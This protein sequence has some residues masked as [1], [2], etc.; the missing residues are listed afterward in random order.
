M[1]KLNIVK[2]VNIFFMFVFLICLGSMNI[3]A[4]EKTV[5]EQEQ[6]NKAIGLNI[7]KN[8]PWQKD[9]MRYEVL[10]PLPEII[11][12][13]KKISWRVEIKGNDSYLGDVYFILKLYNKGVLF[14][15]EPIRVRIEIR[16]EFIVSARNL[17]RD[18]II[19]AKDVFVQKR[20]VRSM[21][22]N[23]VSSIDEVIGKSLCVGLRP[24]M[25]ITRNMLKE[26]SAVKRNKMVQVVLD[27]GPINITTI[28]IA[29]E[30]GSEG[31]FIRVRN[32]SSNK[33]IYAQ[34]VGESKV[35][36]DLH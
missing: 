28:G 34:V 27:N 30:D 13:S 5:I 4:I 9:L 29:E 10:S 8:M 21:P 7:E 19:H 25:E 17:S 36:V 35:K 6:L 24:N 11:F 14:R 22:V 31:S 12:P 23:S 15:E 26:V 1:F 20:W 16:Q 18:T 2:L 3:W 33:V 32:I